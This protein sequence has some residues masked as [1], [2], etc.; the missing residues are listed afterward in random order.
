MTC[1]YGIAGTAS[2]RRYTTEARTPATSLAKAPSM[3]SRASR[4][5]ALRH[6][7]PHGARATGTTSERLLGLA[8]RRAVRRRNL[9]GGARLDRLRRGHLE[10]RAHDRHGRGLYGAMTYAHQDLGVAVA[11][12]ALQVALAVRYARRFR[13]RDE[14]GGQPCSGSTARF[15]ERRL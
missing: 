8:E 12:F 3:R 1:R 2:V 7:F 9:A 15:C 11:L 6:L 5:A 13:F 4:S 14:R 10:R